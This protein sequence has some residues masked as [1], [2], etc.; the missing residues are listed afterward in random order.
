M[1]DLETLLR[2]EFDEA[3]RSVPESVEPW[4]ALQRRLARRRALW[5]GAAA[6]ALLV[7]VAIAVPLSRR[8]APTTPAT[9]APKPSVAVQPKFVPEQGTDITSGPFQIIEQRGDTNGDWIG[10]AYTKR[11]D[12]GSE[13][14]CL[15]VTAKGIPVNTPSLVSDGPVC[16]DPAAADGPVRTYA[17]PT[18]KTAHLFGD[19]LVAVADKGVHDLVFREAAGHPVDL[20]L[21]TEMPRHD[22]YAVYFNGSAQGFGYDGVDAH[23]KH[24]SAIT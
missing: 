2:K 19:I 18:T 13:E 17:L 1:N 6:A 10:W 24:F 5:V 14:L 11:V 7:A 15:S 4:A 12:G 23:G 9:S 21:L 22:V 3:A 8:P 16:V 20:K